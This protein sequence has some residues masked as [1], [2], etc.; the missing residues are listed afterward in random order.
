M[1]RNLLAFASLFL[2]GVDCVRNEFDTVNDEAIPLVGAVIA[3]LIIILA[4]LAICFASY[5]CC[6]RET[7]PNIV[8]MEKPPGE[9]VTINGLPLNFHLR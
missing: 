6:C 1:L 3:I 5:V 2:F 4:V 8:V 9:C 7:A